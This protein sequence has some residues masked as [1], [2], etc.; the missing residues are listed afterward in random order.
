MWIFVI[1]ISLVVIYSIVE[2]IHDYNVIQDSSHNKTYISRWHTLGLIQNSLFFV[3][4]MI[5]L[6][7]INP[8]SCWSLMIASG[9]LFWQLH[10]SILGYMLHKDVFYLGKNKIDAF[11]DQVFWG[12]KSVMVIRMMVILCAVIEYFRQIN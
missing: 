12:G 3:V 10:D 2:G 6:Y 5:G 7:L 9:F 8:V 1:V 4:L 11:L